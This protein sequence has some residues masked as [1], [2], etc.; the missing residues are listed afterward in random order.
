MPQDAVK[1]K[2]SGTSHLQRGE[3]SLIFSPLPD[4]MVL[5]RVSFFQTHWSPGNFLG[6]S[7]SRVVEFICFIEGFITIAQDG[8]Q[9]RVAVFNYLTIVS[10]MDGGAWQATVDRVSKS[11]TRLTDFTFFSFLNIWT[12]FL[13]RIHT[14]FFFLSMII[15]YTFVFKYSLIHLF[16]SISMYFD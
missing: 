2:P 13:V 1:D 14:F 6:S 3:T 8:V 12:K 7:E 5:H 11:R 10:I 9:W 4:A 15:T 16:L